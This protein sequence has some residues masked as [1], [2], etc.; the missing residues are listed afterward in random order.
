M[1]GMTPWQVRAGQGGKGNGGAGVLPLLRSSCY[2]V[3]A[4]LCC[5]GQGVAGCM[6]QVKHDDVVHG[7]LGASP[8]G[9]IG[10]LQVGAWAVIQRIWKSGITAHGGKLN[11]Q[12]LGRCE[13]E[14]SLSPARR[15]QVGAEAGQRAPLGMRGA[16]LLA[17]EGPGILE[18]KCPFNKGNPGAAVPPA[19]AIWYYMPQVRVCG[20]AVYCWI[21][22]LH[23]CCVGVVAGRSLGARLPRTVVLLAGACPARLPGRHRPGS[24]VCLTLVCAFAAAT[25]NGHRP[26]SPPLP[27]LLLLPAHPAIPDSPS[28]ARVRLI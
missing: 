9:L 20:T 11:G 23:C 10:G 8:D 16:G 28:A 15:P 24:A 7:W 2:A 19:H 14:F 4:A 17:G 6:F 18:V 25:P 5:A 21:A 22:V 1:Q 12:T 13:K 27:L 3:H 26:A